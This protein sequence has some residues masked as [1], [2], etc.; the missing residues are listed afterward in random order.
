MIDFCNS[1]CVLRL[2]TIVHHHFFQLRCILC[3]SF[4]ELSMSMLWYLRSQIYW[5]NFESW[6]WKWLLLLA[7]VRGCFSALAH[8]ECLFFCCCHEDWNPIFYSEKAYTF[9]SIKV[10]NCKLTIKPCSL[11]RCILHTFLHTS[12][13]KRHYCFKINSILGL[14]FSLLY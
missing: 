7:F 5:K 9:C 3:R 6:W 11:Q 2:H 13:K 1:S 4:A 14:G 8:R 10:R 12:F